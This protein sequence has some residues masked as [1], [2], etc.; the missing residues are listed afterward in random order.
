MVALFKNRGERGRKSK[1]IDRHH[2]QPQQLV[3]LNG[4]HHGV[5]RFTST[6]D[7]DALSHSSPVRAKNVGLKTRT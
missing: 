7:I 6:L 2:D 3:D 4:K 1:P 5:V